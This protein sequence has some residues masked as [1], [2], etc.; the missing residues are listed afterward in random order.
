[1]QTHLV[2]VAG[3]LEFTLLSSSEL[4]QLALSG[5]NPPVE[6]NNSPCSV[7][8]PE[9]HEMGIEFPTATLSAPS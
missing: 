1:L 6:N 4:P 9:Q 3:P 7:S 2:P 8:Q 5:P